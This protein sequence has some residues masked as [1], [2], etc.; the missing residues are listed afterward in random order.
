MGTSIINPWVFYWAD[1]L[2]H[3]KPIYNFKAKEQK[4][5]WRR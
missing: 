4:P 1:V 3:W 2:E 5:L